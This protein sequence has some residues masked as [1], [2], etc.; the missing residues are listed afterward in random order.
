MATKTNLTAAG[1]A[2]AVEARTEEEKVAISLRPARL[3]G[4]TIALFL[5]GALT[6]GGL[7]YHVGIDDVSGLLGELGWRAPLVLLPYAFISLFDAL[8]WARAISEDGRAR[9]SLWRIYCIRHAGEAISNLTP[10]A[11]LGGE[12]LK[13]YLLRRHGVEAGDGVASVVIAKTAVVCSQFLFTLLG[14]FAFAEWLG[15]LRD[16]AP[17][18]AAGGVGAIAI[19]AVLIFGQ[20]RGVAAKIVRLFDRI[21]ARWSFVEKLERQAKA[22][23]EALLRFYRDDPKGFV[24]AT[25]YHMTG[26]LLGVGEVLFFF[27]L[28]GVACDWRQAL[29]IESLTQATMA[30]AAIIPGGLG[31]QEISGTVI[32][33][34]LGVGEAAGAALMLLKRGREIAF[35]AIGVALIS[36]LSRGTSAQQQHQQ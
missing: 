24:L 11:G 30:A 1:A 31:V 27:A 21:G 22:I 8:G 25:C 29:M 32:C 9:I 17:M 36:W 16:R 10:T 33:G 35:T 4:R 23:D 20:R 28:M 15:L 18:L 5:L 3:P 26:W 14:L 6:V 7:L 19:C 34:M 2:A 12:P 13:A